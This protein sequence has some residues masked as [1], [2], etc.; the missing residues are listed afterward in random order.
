MSK[1]LRANG[2]IQRPP[3][4]AF[5]PVSTDVPDALLVGLRLRA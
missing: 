5:T 4:P 2:S 3:K 1:K